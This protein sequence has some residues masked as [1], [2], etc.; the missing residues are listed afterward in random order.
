[1]RPWRL[2]RCRLLP[3]QQMGV[4]LTFILE[5]EVYDRLPQGA[6]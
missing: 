2:R 3:V 1:M 5:A 4:V 6:L